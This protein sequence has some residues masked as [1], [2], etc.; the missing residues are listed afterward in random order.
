MLHRKPSDKKE[1]DKKESCSDAA[2]LLRFLRLGKPA[3]TSRIHPAL[4]AVQGSLAGA[5]HR[6]MHSSLCKSRLAQI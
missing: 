4:Y 2:C 3:V 1:K 5:H 6:A